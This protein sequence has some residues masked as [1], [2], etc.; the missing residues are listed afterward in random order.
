[1]YIYIIIGFIILLYSTYGSNKLYIE[2]YTGTNLSTGTV[3][4]F[5]GDSRAEIK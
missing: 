5:S 4:S 1:M 2:N 3:M